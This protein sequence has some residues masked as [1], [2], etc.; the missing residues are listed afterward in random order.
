MPAK[1]KMAVAIAMALATISIMHSEEILRPI[2]VTATRTST[3]ADDVPATVT[4]QT[5]REIERRL[6]ADETDLFKDEPDIAVARDLCRI[7][8]DASVELGFKQIDVSVWPEPRT[9]EEE[10]LRIRA[11]AALKKSAD[12]LSWR[13][14][15]AAWMSEACVP[16]LSCA[17]SA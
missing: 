14:R 17:C 10:A 1:N 4:T 2:T 13:A 15:C 8:E 11:Q 6:P 12:R 9:G 7:A 5:A 3:A 16:P